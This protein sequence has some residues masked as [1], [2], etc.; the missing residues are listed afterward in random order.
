MKATKKTAIASNLVVMIEVLKLSKR[1][2][3][4]VNSMI[5]RWDQ[6]VDPQEPKTPIQLMAA[7]GIIEP[8]RSK[9]KSSDK[10]LS[11]RTTRIDI[12]G[13]S[14]YVMPTKTNQAMPITTH[15]H[16]TSHLRPS[17]SSLPSKSSTGE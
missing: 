16:F 1:P 15:V 14:M 3:Q 5:S 6:S 7:H 2:S 17:T 10:K 13:S 9:S 8:K 12:A 4:R 11:K